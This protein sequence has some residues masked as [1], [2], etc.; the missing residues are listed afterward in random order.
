M[1]ATMPH[2]YTY[3]SALKAALKINWRVEDLIGTDKHLDFT[4][5]FLPE[6]LAK[7][8]TIPYLNDVEKLKLNQIRANSYLHIFGLVEEFIVPLVIDHV[9]HLGCDDID[10]TH[11]FLCFA[12]EESK[13]IDLFRRFTQEFER[14]FGTSCECIGPSKAIAEAVLKHSALGVALVTLH[15]EWMTQSHYLESVR[16]NHNED[17]DPQF[18]SLLRHH[19][20]EE[21]QHA[22]LDTLMVEK[23]ARELDAPAIEQGIEDYF[24]IVRMFNEGFKTQVRLDIDSLSRATK[25]TFTDEQMQ[26]IQSIQE[27]SYQWTFLGSGMLHQNFVQT[28]SQLNPS[29]EARIAELAQEF[30]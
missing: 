29:V 25:R 1:V 22:K 3:E 26:E 9:R 23:L 13:H 4:K 20:L 21:A 10:A 11:A 8:N 17:L 18:C 24:A 12:E 7:S 27:K 15:V 19:W 14:G 16:N 28:I 30:S 6:S 2:N 5:P